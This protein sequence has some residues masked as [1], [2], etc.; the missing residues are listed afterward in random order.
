MR[1]VGKHVPG[2]TCHTPKDNSLHFR[3]WLKCKGIYYF[4]I[5]YYY[6]MYINLGAEESDRWELLRLIIN[7]TERRDLDAKKDRRMNLLSMA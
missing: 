3:T 5:S 4:F 7:M 2:F 6:C 1:N